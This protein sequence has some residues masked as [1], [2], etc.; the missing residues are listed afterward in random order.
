MA[1]TNKIFVGIDNER[2]E[3]V[4]TAKEEFLALQEIDKEQE[5][6]LEALALEKQQKR[7]DAITKLGEASGLTTDEINAIL[8]I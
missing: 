2:I 8:N 1:S 3:L 4:G 7:V 5:L 6:L